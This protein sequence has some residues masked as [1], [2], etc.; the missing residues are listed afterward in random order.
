MDP[1]PLS[2]E[3]ASAASIGAHEVRFVDAARSIQQPKD[4]VVSS[5]L[6]LAVHLDR[7]AEPKQIIVAMNSVL[8]RRC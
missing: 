6:P 2:S 7:N 8:A 3:I 4:R 5:R 1:L